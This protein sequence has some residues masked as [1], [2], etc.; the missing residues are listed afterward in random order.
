M[1][2]EMVFLKDFGGVIAAL[3]FMYVFAKYVTGLAFEQ[4]KVNNER[5]FK[6]MDDTYKENAKAMND[7]VVTLK[8]HTRS[9]EAAIDELK[10]HFNGAEVLLE[11]SP[12]PY[13]RT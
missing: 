7:L 6:F 2:Q 4:I 11:P 5:I 9:K 1:L 3:A 12:P 8:D 13:R 10:R